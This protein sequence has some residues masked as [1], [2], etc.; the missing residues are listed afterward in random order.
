MDTL[1]W[2]IAGIWSALTA[3]SLLALRL[4]PA[5]LPGTPAHP[6]GVTAVVAARDEEARI[7]QTVRGLLAQ[8]HAPLRLAVVDDRSTDHTPDIL[9]GLAAEDPRLTPLRV[10]SLPDGW[11]GKCHACRTGAQAADTEWLLFIDADVHLTPGAVAAALAE[12]ERTGAAHVTLMPGMSR[13]QGLGPAALLAA[14]MPFMVRS[15]MANLGVPGQAVGIGGF[16]LVRRDVY[17]SFG[18]HDALRLEIVDDLYLAAHMNAAGARTRVLRAFDDA[19]VEYGVSLRGLLAVTTKNN[20][21][22]FR[23]RVAA[24][25]FTLAAFAVLWCGAVL[26]PVAGSVPGYAAA[27]GLLSTIVPALILARLQGWPIVQGLLAPL[28]M[29]A[30]PL[31][32]LNSMA[33]T[34]RAGGV[35]W[36]E[37]LY[38]LSELRAGRARPGRGGNRPS[39]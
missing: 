10:E 19:E 27:G 9:A 37:T 34:L 22:I 8:T 13:C 26:G 1:L 23:F 5:L 38:P 16:N 39:S 2:T 7:A 30:M 25:V 21:A 29:L 3:L 28:G 4:V 24:A 20:F 36:R 31:M 18:G 6:A 35:R 14:M 33:A 15:A 32:L 11:L 17:E 12:A